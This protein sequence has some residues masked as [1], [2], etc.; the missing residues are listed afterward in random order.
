MLD[1][2]LNKDVAVFFSNDFRIKFI[3]RL[4][5]N[6]VLEIVFVGHKSGFK[7]ALKLFEVSESYF[8]IFII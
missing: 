5:V 3:N 1:L 6:K 4:L 8:I 7:I 2:F